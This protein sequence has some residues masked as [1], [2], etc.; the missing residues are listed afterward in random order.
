LG[1]LALAR[2]LQGHD[3]GR[4][5]VEVLH[6]PLDGAALAGR[7]AALEQDDQP[8]PGGLDPV[9]ELQQLD[10]QQSLGP[11]IFLAPHPLGVGIAFPPGIHRPTVGAHQHR[12]VVIAVVHAQVGQLS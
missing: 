7:V 2:L 6:E 8:L 11:F 3:P 12:L 9:L 5:R 10:L 4:A 1:A